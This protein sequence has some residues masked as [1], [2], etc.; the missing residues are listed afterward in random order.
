MP[1]PKDAETPGITIFLSKEHLAEL[2]ARRLAPVAGRIDIQPLSRSAWIK[3]LAIKDLE[4]AAAPASA[5]TPSP[6]TRGKKKA[7]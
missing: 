3:M 2:D 7:A 1:K 6:E 5:P 4:P